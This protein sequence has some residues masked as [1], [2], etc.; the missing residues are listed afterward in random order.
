MRSS[1]C[2]PFCSVASGANF[3]LLR[4][5]HMC[6]GYWTAT[7]QFIDSCCTLKQTLA[8][9]PELTDSIGRAAGVAKLAMPLLLLAAWKR[10]RCVLVLCWK[11]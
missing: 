2:A 11:L 8:T 4:S 1:R 6:S 7:G 5:Y 3:Q 10:L 9:A